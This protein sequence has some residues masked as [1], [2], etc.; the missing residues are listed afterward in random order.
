MV[1]RG[2]RL[3]LF[4]REDTRAARAEREDQLQRRLVNGLRVLASTLERAA[5]V[6]EKFRL[7]RK[8]YAPQ[9]QWLEREPPPR[10]DGS[11]GR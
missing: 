1:R 9:E 4:R 8:G 11:D 3:P 6:V 5:D 10:G 7:A 2:M